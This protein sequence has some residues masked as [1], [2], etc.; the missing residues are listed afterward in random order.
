MV[1]GITY[2]GLYVLLNDKLTN[3]RSITWTCKVYN[4]SVFDDTISCMWSTKWGHKQCNSLSANQ[5]IRLTA[6]SDNQPI[7]V[8]LRK[9]MLSLWRCQCS[10]DLQ[11]FSW[12]EVLCGW[13]SLVSRWFTLRLFLFGGWKWCGPFMKSRLSFGVTRLTW[14]M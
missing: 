13:Y 5:L 3:K 1:L 9:Q 14:R 7:Q 8:H 11:C 6:V 12:S 10:G 4:V 2:V